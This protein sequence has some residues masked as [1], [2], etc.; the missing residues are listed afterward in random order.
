VSRTA[1]DAYPFG[2]I[3]G[4]NQAG[5]DTRVILHSYL[6]M[7]RKFGDALGPPGRGSDALEDRALLRCRGTN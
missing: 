1:S 4:G 5:V 6:V 7:L 3:W 2:H